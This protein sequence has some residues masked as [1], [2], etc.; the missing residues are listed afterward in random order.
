MIVD[1]VI[2]SLAL[3]VLN[4]SVVGESKA[5]R[6]G[7][8]QRRVPGAVA[9]GPLADPQVLRLQNRF[10]PVA[11][12]PGSELGVALNHR[13]RHIIHQRANSREILD[14][15]QNGKQNRIGRR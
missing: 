11:T 15:T 14:R 5:H 4:R 6:Y 13:Q 3:G 8:D 2:P 1:S 12:A 7:R 10:C 9:T